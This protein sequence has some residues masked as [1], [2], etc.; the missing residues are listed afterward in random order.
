MLLFWLSAQVIVHERSD[1]V[2][3]TL[4]DLIDCALVST[5]INL[6]LEDVVH[7]DDL[8]V[9]VCEIVLAP[10]AVG[11]CNRWPDCRRGN[12]QVLDDHPFG[13][14]LRLVEAH[15]LEVFVFDFPKHVEG[16]VGK[17]QLF[18]VLRLVVVLVK[19]LNLKPKTLP[20]NLWLLVATASVLGITDSAFAACGLIEHELKPHL[21]T[22]AAEQKLVVVLTFVCCHQELRAVEAHRSK[23]LQ[24]VREQVRVKDSL[25]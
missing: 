25:G 22:L 7:F 4:K 14:A 10:V 6:H 19:M 11:H 3:E 20:R 8:L 16:F 18:L 5:S 12:R 2:L 1:V 21:G 23:G 9:G 13:P 15:K 17:E 24:E